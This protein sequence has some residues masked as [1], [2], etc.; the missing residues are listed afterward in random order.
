MKFIKFFSLL[1]LLYACAE[2]R[3]PYDE[4]HVPSAFEIFAITDTLGTEYNYVVP[5]PRDTVY[6]RYRVEKDTIFNEDG[7]YKVENDTIYYKGKTALLFEPE[8]IV[9]PK[10]ANLLKIHLSSNARWTA[11][12]IPFNTEAATWVRNQMEGGIGDAVI[13]YNIKVRGSSPTISTRRKEQTQF[14]TTRDSSIIYKL[15]FTQKA[16]TED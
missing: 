15:V 12:A 2:D 8:L 10:Y 16:M 3:N 5:I 9:L 4:R 13:E 11:P 7:S 6:D 1:L 14:I